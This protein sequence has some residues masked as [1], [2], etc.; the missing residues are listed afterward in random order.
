MANAAEFP[1][2]GEDE[3]LKWSALVATVPT[4]GDAGCAKGAE[5][6]GGEPIS[7]FVSVLLSTLYA[8]VEGDDA[9]SGLLVL[10]MSLLPNK[11]TDGFFSRTG[12]L[13]LFSI[14]GRSLSWVPLA[15]SWM[16]WAFSWIP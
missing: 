2:G 6:T 14:W 9:K 3:G 13:W 15:F 7:L 12:A 8:D 4:I 5:S 11:P 1:S 10:L 16:P